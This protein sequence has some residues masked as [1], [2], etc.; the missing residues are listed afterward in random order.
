MANSHCE[1]VVIDR[2]RDYFVWI[3]YERFWFSR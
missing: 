1:S 3:C 2:L